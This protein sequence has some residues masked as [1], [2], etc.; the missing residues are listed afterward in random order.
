MFYGY[1]NLKGNEL[2]I[3]IKDE[4]V[5]QNTVE[6][7]RF[8]KEH[9]YNII[10]VIKKALQ[11]KVKIKLTDTLDDICQTC[12]SKHKKVCKEFIPYEVSATSDDRATLHFYGLKKRAYTSEY[13]VK[14][15]LKKGIF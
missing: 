1:A 11:P 9:G 6:N 13:L 8:S 7:G 14:R 5:L 3:K 10:D 4:F 15:V 2:R 12:N